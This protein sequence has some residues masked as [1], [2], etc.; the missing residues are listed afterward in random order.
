MKVLFLPQTSELG[1]SSRYRVYQLL[2]LLRKSGIEC[3]VSPAIDSDLYASAYLKPGGHRPIGFAHKIWRR[4]RADLE[5]IAQFDAVFVQKGVFPGLHAGF[6]RRFAARKPLVFDFDD[7]IWLPREGG[8]PLPRALHREHVVQDILRHAA[9]VIAGN[10]F[11]A[12]YARRFNQ[13]V[14]VIPSAI[15]L[16]RYPPQLKTAA[17][18]AGGQPV[19][20]WIGSRTT[21]PYLGALRRVFEKLQVIPR[22]IASGDP[23]VLGFAV[24]F[25]SWRLESE[26]VELT[27]VDIGIAPLPDTAWEQGKCGVK[28]LQFM[29]CGIPVVASPVGVHNAIVRHGANGFLARNP[30]EWC[31]HL[32]ELIGNA[33]LRERLGRAGRET[34]EQ[35]YDVRTVAERVA[36]VLCS[37]G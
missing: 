21:L 20:G 26:L 3:E 11:L 29:A 9:A 36:S 4:R 10:G 2:P 23:A 37:L 22:V 35:H 12:E 18:N 32:G 6:E 13:N 8:S 16:Q 14:M 25:R 27:Q 19:I 15:D 1:P 17:M 28:L 30:V 34:V 33:P 5:R 7:A 31:K 24:D